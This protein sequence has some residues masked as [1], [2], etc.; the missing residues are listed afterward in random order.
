M[1]LS[2]SSFP[3]MFMSEYTYDQIKSNQIK[4]FHFHACQIFARP[5]HSISLSLHRHHEVVLIPCHLMAPVGSISALIFPFVRSSNVMH[6]KVI[7]C[8][9]HP[10]I[11]RS[12]P[13]P[14]LSYPI[15][16]SFDI[17]SN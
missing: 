1:Y 17:Y 2:N 14:V 16:M 7:G 6:T 4:S 12:I 9:I 5:F 8:V 11:H 10:L 13:N 3:P 15:Q